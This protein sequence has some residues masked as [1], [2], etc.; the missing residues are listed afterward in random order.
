[1]T[2]LIIILA[3]AVVILPLSA[4]IGEAAFRLRMMIK[5]KDK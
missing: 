3:A 1:M 5:D 2:F 4:L